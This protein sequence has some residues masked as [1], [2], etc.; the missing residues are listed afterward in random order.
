M[1]DSKKANIGGM[2]LH[3]AADWQRKTRSAASA[4]GWCR[5]HA[6]WGIGHCRREAAGAQKGRPKAASPQEMPSRDQ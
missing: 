3:V 5:R 1:R 2:W 4:H 6:F